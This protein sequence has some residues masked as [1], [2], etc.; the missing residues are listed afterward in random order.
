[1]AAATPADQVVEASVDGE[2]VRP[3]NAAV[4]YHFPF[5]KSIRA[6]SHKVVV[7]YP[8]HPR[9]WPAKCGWQ[10]GLADV[11]WPIMELPT[12]HK[13][14]CDRCFKAEKE[15]ARAVAEVRVR[16]VGVDAD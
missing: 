15:A 8:E 13:A 1:M 3:A 5:V 16:E 7:G 4:D 10:F 6:T 9:R 11:A 14:I 2:V 12:C